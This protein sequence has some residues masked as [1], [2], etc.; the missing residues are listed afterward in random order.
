MGAEPTAE[1]EGTG[2]SNA[3][4]VYRVVVEVIEVV[5]LNAFEEAGHNCLGT[6]VQT[7]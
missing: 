4:P 6:V 7:L 5:R 1:I 2:V 3:D